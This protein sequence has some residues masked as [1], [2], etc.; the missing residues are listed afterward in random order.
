MNFIDL[1][2]QQ[3]LIRKNIDFNIKKVL[4]HGQYIMGPEVF[5]L[6][7]KLAQ[8]VGV[9]HCIGVS[10]GTDAL[11]ISMM[12]LGI[13]PGDEIITSPFT[14]IATIEMIVLLGAKP[15]YVDIEKSTFN[16]DPGKIKSA[17]T[18]KT[19]LIL[20]VSLFGQCANFD[21]INIIASEFNL[22]VLEDGAQSFG[23]MRNKK[24]SCSLSTIG[25][26]SFFPSKPLGCYGD[27][28]AIFTNDDELA[29]IMRDLRIHGQSKR[30]QHQRAG[31]NGRLDTIQ[32]AILLSKFE[33]FPQEL[34]MRHEI[35][36]RYAELLN[37]SSSTV[38]IPSILT[39]N[40]HI[41]SQYSV[42]VDDRDKVS[43]YLSEMG[44]P[45][46]IHYPIPAH[47]QKAFK[48]QEFTLLVSES[49]SKDILS[50]PMHPYLKYSDQKKIVN[51]FLSTVSS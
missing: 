46:A 3:K 23:A 45:T 25:C 1:K 13:G 2:A 21:A 18:K 12:A 24:K 42:L 30:Y 43:K 27:G 32:A 37:D 17:I 7:E 49:V 11:L 29:A 14:F 6:E 36:Q 16:I 20:P 26:T 44:V 8:Y 47:C 38:T 19:K 51:L 4:D 28:G 41:F 48:S 15:I 40:T 35:A 9:K 50:L 31:I 5:E 33:I 22:P 39:G 10:S 34:L